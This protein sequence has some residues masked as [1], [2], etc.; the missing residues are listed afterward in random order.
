MLGWT[1][2]LGSLAVVDELQGLPET[3]PQ[4]PAGGSTWTV[5]DLEDARPISLSTVRT[6][7]NFSCMANDYENCDWGDASSVWDEQSVQGRARGWGLR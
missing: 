6:G 3:S 5:G 1:A 2:H 4:R 7:N